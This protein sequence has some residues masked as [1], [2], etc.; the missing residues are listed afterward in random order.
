M[1]LFRF[2]LQVVFTACR[3]AVDI[4]QFWLFLLAVVAG[5]VAGFFPPLLRPFV[6]DVTTWHVLVA[7]LAVVVV[8]RLLLAPYWLWEEARAEAAHAQA[9]LAKRLSDPESFKATPAYVRLKLLLAPGSSLSPEAR[10]D[11]AQ[12]EF[13]RL[14]DLADGGDIEA[15]HLSACVAE[16]LMECAR[17][18]YASG[19]RFHEIQSS[20]LARLQR[21]QRAL[22]TL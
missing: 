9:A 20:V 19:G 1:A 14:A 11:A 15:T 2:Y 16:W 5:A 4:A 10:L 18:Y 21:M 3:H 8:G 17:F 6:P 22:P 7:V 13:D 12:K